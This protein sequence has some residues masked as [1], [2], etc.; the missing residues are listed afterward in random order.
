[1]IAA[2]I[3]DLK[4]DVQPLLTINAPALLHVPI[5]RVIVVGGLSRRRYISRTN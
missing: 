1:M 3:I 5:Y 4:T 2:I